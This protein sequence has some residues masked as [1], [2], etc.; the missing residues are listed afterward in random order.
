MDKAMMDMLRASFANRRN[1][2]NW[3]GERKFERFEECSG[4]KLSPFSRSF[5]NCPLKGKHLMSTNC[6]KD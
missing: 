1:E 5:K 3:S 2:H 4:F 6:T